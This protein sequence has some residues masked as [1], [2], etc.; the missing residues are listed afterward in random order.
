MLSALFESVTSFLIFRGNPQ[1]TQSVLF[2]L[3][4]SFGLASWSQLPIPAVAL[5]AGDAY[6]LSQARSLNALAMGAE[7]A[8]SLGVDVRRLRRN[9]FIVTSLMAGVAVAVS[10]VIG[11][12]GL[13]VPHIVRLMVG[14]DHRRVLPVGRAVRR[15]VH[16][17]GRPAGAD[18]RRAAGDADRRDHRVHRRADPDR[19][20]PPPP[21][22]VRGDR[23][24]LRLHDLAVDIA[25]RR[26]VTGIDLTVADGEFAGL[27]GPNGSGKS[28]ILKAIYRVHRPAAGRVLLDGA[29]LLA[30]RPRDAARRIAVVA[31]EITVEFDFTVREMVMI[32]RTPHK[33]AFDRDDRRRPRHRRP[34]HRAGRLRSTSPLAASTRCPA[35]RSSGC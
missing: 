29:D 11:F 8:A 26:I 3:L 25:G 13:V 28:T 21:L 2:W 20:D 15:L 9:L 6:L 22:P 16:G 32:G 4:G 33:R 7:P 31:Q 18:D 5:A 10:G 23:M 30:L 14:S 12:V 34:G 35:A 24:S 19:A 27:L 17:P 1:A